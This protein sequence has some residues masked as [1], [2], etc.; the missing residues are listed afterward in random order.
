MTTKTRTVQRQK[1]GRNELKRYPV[2]GLVVIEDSS[3]IHGGQ[4]EADH[5]ITRTKRVCYIHSTCRSGVNAVKV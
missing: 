4:G 1:V 2:D 5:M 3:G